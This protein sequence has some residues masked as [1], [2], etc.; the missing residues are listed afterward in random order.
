[1]LKIHFFNINCTDTFREICSN[2]V[3]ASCSIYTV[4][5]YYKQLFYQPDFIKVID[6]TCSGEVFL[7]LSVFAGDQL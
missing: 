1:M 5:S 7:P 6:Y 2:Q 3:I 4:N